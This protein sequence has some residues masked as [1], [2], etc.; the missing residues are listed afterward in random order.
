[1]TRKSI[2]AQNAR[3]I[4]DDAETSAWL[5]REPRMRAIVNGSILSDLGLVNCDGDLIKRVD[6]S[7]LSVCLPRSLAE[8]VAQHQASCMDQIFLNR[9]E[10]K[11]GTVLDL[12]VEAVD[13][14]E[15]RLRKTRPALLL[16][17][18]AYAEDIDVVPHTVI[19]MMAKY[20][21]ELS[22]PWLVI[23]RPSVEDVL[24]GRGSEYTTR[25]IAKQDN[26]KTF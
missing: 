4:L 16:S 25:K 19:H 12:L 22:R 14:L 23:V 15:G 20:W 5:L 18:V 3:K 8:F 13:D 2:A 21:F 9:F 6:T 17:V 10:D 24:H 7:G 26:V 11:K 1:M